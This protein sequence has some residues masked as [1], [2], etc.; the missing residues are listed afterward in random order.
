MKPFIARALLSVTAIFVMTGT[1]HAQ[2]IRYSWMEMSFMGQDVSRTGSLPTPGVPDQIVDV[3]VSDGTGVRFRGS[4]GTWNNL[5]LVFQYAATDIDLTGEVTNPGNPPAGFD[6]E[7]DYTSIR[8]GVG[9]KYSIFENTDIFGELTYDRVG[10]DFGSFAGE[11]FDMDRQEAGGALG[12][13]TLFGD[14]FMVQVHGRYSGVGDADLTTG[15]FDSDTL[16]GAG[17]AWEFIRGM[18]FVGDVES[19]EFSSY[20]LGLRI[21]LDED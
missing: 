9:I 15:L 10:F 6:D 12:I 17:F 3:S 18:S 5:Y 8:G 20:S 2:E 13:R 19:G 7:F 1:S 11:N 14:H 21:D 4:F 16:F